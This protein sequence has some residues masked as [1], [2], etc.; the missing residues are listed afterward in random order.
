M[1]RFFSCIIFLTFTF[2]VH[3]QVVQKIDSKLFKSEVT[4]N[5]RIVI[6]LKDQADISAVKG[7]RGKDTKA[8]F[9]YNA[10]VAKANDTQTDLLEWLKKERIFFR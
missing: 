6:V 3:A 10:L 1:I 4:K 9:V 2:V 7:M 5:Q 8:T